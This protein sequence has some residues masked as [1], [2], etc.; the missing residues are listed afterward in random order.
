METLKKKTSTKDGA[1]RQSNFRE[2]QKKLGRRG[3]L[4]FLTDEE[5]LAVDSFLHK[6]RELS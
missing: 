1:L 6:L 2:K 5:K 3:R 4:Y